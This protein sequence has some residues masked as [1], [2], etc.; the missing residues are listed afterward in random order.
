[1]SGRRW[2]WLVALAGPGVGALL[3]VLLEPT[4]TASWI[5]VVVG[6]PL[7]A[8]L[9]G[10]AMWSTLSVP[11]VAKLVAAAVTAVAMLLAVVPIVFF[12][13]YLLAVF[14]FGDDDTVYF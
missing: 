10:A 7:T 8:L 9:G 2:L 14:L 6:W 3:V 11:R 12:A 5:V 13:S 4:A 1:V